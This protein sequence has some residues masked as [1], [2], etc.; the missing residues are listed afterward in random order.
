MRFRLDENIDVRGVAVLS[1]AGH[2]AATV[3]SDLAGATDTVIAETVEAEGRA[4]SSP[5]TAVSLTCAP[6]G[7]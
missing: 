3:A 6:T 2:D 7:P 1:D 5:V 4:W